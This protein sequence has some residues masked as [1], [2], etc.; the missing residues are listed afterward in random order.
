MTDP[1]ADLLTRIRNALHARHDTVVVPS[2][3]VK[4]AIVRILVEE[5]YLARYVKQ[6]VAPQAQLT[7][8]LKYGSKQKAVIHRIAR[9]SKPGGRIYKGHK[10]A[11]PA[12]KM[13]ISILSTPKGILTHKQAF[14][15]KVGGEVLCEVW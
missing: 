12:I 4:E 14:A 6:D 7:L 3:R 9:I 11:R 10:D 2:S 5:G 8:F 1:I 13:G 15:A